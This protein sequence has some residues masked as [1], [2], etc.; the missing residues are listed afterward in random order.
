MNPQQRAYLVTLGLRADATDAEA[1]AFFDARNAEEQTHCRS[2]APAPAPTPPAPQPIPPVVPAPVEDARSGILAEGQRMER[3]RVIAVRAVATPDIPVALIE[4]A[5]AEGWDVA[6]A[7]SEFLAHYRGLAPKP[8]SSGA[9]AV[10]TQPELTRDALAGALLSRCGLGDVALRQL[11]DKPDDCRRVEQAMDRGR[12]MACFSLVDICREAVR[13]SGA[14]DP[15]T[16]VEPIERDEYIRAGLASGALSYIFTTS[17]NAAMRQGYEEAPDTSDWVR[18]VDVRD[19]QTQEEL[20]VKVSGGLERIGPGGIA[21]QAS[22]SDVRETWKIYRFAKQAVLDEMD[23][24]NDRL[25]ALNEFPLELGRAA[26]RIKPDMVY[27]LLIANP[28][29]VADSTALFDASTHVNLTS[30]A[31]SA[32]SLK[33]GITA[34]R[35]QTWNSININ[36]TP[37]YLIL[38]SDLEW[39]AREL[40]QSTQLIIAGTAASVTERGN[41]NTLYG[42]ALAIR[43][44]PRLS[45]GVIDPVTGTAYTG[46][47]TKWYLAASPAAGRT[48]KVG[49]RQGTGRRPQVRSFTL[50]EGKW[51]VGW[52][53]NMDIGAAAMDY[54]G[55]F[56]G[57]A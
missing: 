23:L 25:G 40:L 34:M 45:N 6:R 32:A 53:I 18:E 19:F 12:R 43:S 47:A 29:L 13:M 10:H 17:V 56:I 11:K 48:I 52:D 2:I 36:L 51:G 38:S 8:V 22:I 54:R 35:K 31:L 27:S 57:N 4:R 28:T 9:P 30:A 24:I 3:E 26:R 46:T 14:R 41:M 33:A 21:K 42:E 5:V 55:M 37:A 49:Y 50:S 1:Q 7:N 16:G 44:E 39:T 20:D 15:M